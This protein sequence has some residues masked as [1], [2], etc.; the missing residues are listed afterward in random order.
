MRGKAKRTFTGWGFFLALHFVGL[1]AP[2]FTQD[3]PAKLVSTEWLAAHLNDENIRIVDMRMDIRDYWQSHIPGAVYLD[4]AALR[5][6]D[7]GVPSKVL[8]PEGLA[9]LLGQTGIREDTKVVVY[10]DKNGYPSLY[11]IWAL[12]LIGHKFSASLEDG[13]ERWRKEGRPLTQD[14]PVIKPVSYRLPAKMPSDVRA[15]AED[16]RKGLKSGA[17]VLDVRPADLYSGEKGAWKRKG[18]IKGAVNHFWALDMNGDGTWKRREELAAAYEKIGV[19]AEKTVIVYCGQ[20]QMAAHTYFA[21]RH[22][23]GF[24]NIKLFDGSFNEWSAR[25]DLPVEVSK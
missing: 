5:W 20:G 15:T 22:V 16:V 2:S 7:R 13:I 8:P 12:D 21:L 14:F 11:L 9:L 10:Y 4:P 6:P 17:V 23:L 24:P 25:D 19:T 18:H 1:A 3:R